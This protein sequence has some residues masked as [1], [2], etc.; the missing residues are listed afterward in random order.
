[1]LI[2]NMNKREQTIAIITISFVLVAMLYS[3]VLEPVF[4][5]WR[6]LNNQMKSKALVLKKDLA[7]LSSRK[8]LE[9][10][11][12][13]FSKYVISDKSE[14][15]AISEVLSYLENLSRTDSCILQNIKPV[16]TKDYGTYKELLIELT[17]EGSIKQFTKFLYDIENTKNMILKV[18]H[19]VLTSKAGQDGALKG[20]FL[21]SK[22]ILE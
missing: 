14:E 21:I 2:K 22:V 18:R 4:R 13:K 7:M 6:A 10:K 1:M 9:A 3:F 16:G 11:Y 8:I 15:E 19:F 5:G 12:E 20:S 17:S